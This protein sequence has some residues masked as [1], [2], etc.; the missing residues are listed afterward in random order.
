MMDI[1]PERIIPSGEYIVA[2]SENTVLKAYLGTCVGVTICDSKANVGGLIHLL[3]PEP[4]GSHIYYQPETYATTGMPLFIQAILDAGGQKENL[5]VCIAGGALVGPVTDLDLSLDIGG[6]TAEVVQSIL[7]QH[8]ISITRMETGGYFS[9]ILELDLSTLKTEINPIAI[10]D[11]GIETDIKKPDASDIEMAIRRVRP[12]PQIALKILRMIEKDNYNMKDIGEEV[13][14]DQVISAKVINLCNSAMIGLRVMVDSVDHALVILGE[15]RLLQLILSVTVET[16]FPVSAQGYSLCKGGIFQHALGTAM[17]AGELSSFTGRS[18]PEVAYTA[19]LLHDIGKIPL[20][21]YV[22]QSTPYF[23]RS[24]QEDE[25]ELL[26]TEKERF[27]ITHPEA[28]GILGDKWNLPDNLTDVIRHHHHPEHAE[29][30]KDLVT[31]T[32]LADLLM[33]RFQVAHEIEKINTDQLKERLNVLGIDQDKLAS[34][35][36]RIPRAIFQLSVSEI[37]EK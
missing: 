15:K 1:K 33:S 20:D 28:G 22:A 5:E 8:G 3:L 36:D 17:I 12:I 29:K 10:T 6:R 11:T 26:D 27:G 16:M 21:Q 25:T 35:V 19:G 2:K 9:C 18:T 23:Y 34:I 37:T 31:L 24:I 14:Q 30:D 32:Y 4:T 7:N 13:R